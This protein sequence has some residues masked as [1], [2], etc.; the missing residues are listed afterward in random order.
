MLKSWNLRQNLEDKAKYVS[1]WLNGAI[2][3]IK[4]EK[5]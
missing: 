5:L 4:N 2:L 1:R 3:G